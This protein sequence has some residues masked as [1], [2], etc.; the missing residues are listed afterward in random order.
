M[1]CA[2]HRDYG[3]YIIPQK[4]VWGVHEYKWTCLNK[5]VAFIREN[6][7]GHISIYNGKSMIYKVDKVNGKIV[8]EKV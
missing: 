1:Y 2:R 8:L 4:V 6:G 3:F 5:L 7:A